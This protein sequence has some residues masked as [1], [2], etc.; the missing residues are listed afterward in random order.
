MYVTL[1][2][3][4]A[5]GLQKVA[6][7]SGSHYPATPHLAKARMDTDAMITQQTLRV[8]YPFPFNTS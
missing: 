2:I 3:S 5:D 1:V 4:L 8:W 6:Q 7:L